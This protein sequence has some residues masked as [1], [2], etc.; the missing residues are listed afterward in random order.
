MKRLKSELALCYGYMLNQGREVTHANMESGSS[1][2]TTQMK[3]AN[4]HCLKFEAFLTTIQHL[5]LNVELIV[6]NVCTHE[7]K[8]DAE[9]YYRVLWDDICAGSADSSAG[10]EQFINYML[11]YVGYCKIKTSLPNKEVDEIITGDDKG[12]M[13]SAES[14]DLVHIEFGKKLRLITTKTAQQLCGLLLNAVRQQ[15]VI[16]KQ[17]LS[18]AKRY[19]ACTFKPKINT[20]AH[21][22]K[23]LRER[24]VRNLSSS[25]INYSATN[26]HI[27]SEHPCPAFTEMSIHELLYHDSKRKGM[28]LEQRCIHYLATELKDCPFRPNIPSKGLFSSSRIKGK[29]VI[30]SDRAL[31]AHE[32][33]FTHR[34][35]RTLGD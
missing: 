25:V 13:V 21:D 3:P 20:I 23:H 28:K 34:L 9:N 14:A 35:V 32:K 10:V 26:D 19:E 15:Q 18:Y 30:H 5:G 33:L 2:P 1:S 4:K 16:H 22:I 31:P 8:I 29:V 17:E 6:R 24:L 7:Y 12:R 27:K 11:P